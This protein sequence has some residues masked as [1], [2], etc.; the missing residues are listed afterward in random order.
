MMKD[1]IDVSVCFEASNEVHPGVPHKRHE[2]MA[3]ESTRADR[4]RR[5][6]YREDNRSNPDWI[7]IATEAS[8]HVPLALRATHAERSPSRTL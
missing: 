2:P 4:P 1:V 7:A 3:L 5:I 6:R 8:R